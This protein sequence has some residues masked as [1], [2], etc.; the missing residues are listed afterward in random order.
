ME[1]ARNRTQWTPVVVKPCACRRCKDC[2]TQA[3]RERIARAQERMFLDC[4]NARPDRADEVLR[5]TAA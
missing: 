5:L 4:D 2:Q 3:N 1:A